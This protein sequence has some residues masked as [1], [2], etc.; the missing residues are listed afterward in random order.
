MTERPAKGTTAVE[1]P[2]VPEEPTPERDAP[3]RLWKVC[4]AAL[5]LLVLGF[6]ALGILSW[7]RVRHADEAAQ[8]DQDVLAAARSE[9]EL[10]A[11]LRHDSARNSL[12]QL[13]AGATGAFLAQFATADTAF[14]ALLDQGQVDSTGRVAAAAV[15]RADDKSADV[16]V[17]VSA[18]VRNTDF[19]AGQARDYRALVSLTLQNG[20]WLVADARVVP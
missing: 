9:L 20:H 18:V 16:L 5:V 7:Q 14:F 19:P 11:N 15:Q 2:P 6:A 8:R 13:R 4:A 12:D 17:A 3:S 1:D 10:M